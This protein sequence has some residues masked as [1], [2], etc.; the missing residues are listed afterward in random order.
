MVSAFL[1]CSPAPCYLPAIT[2]SEGIG[3]TRLTADSECTLGGIY[4]CLGERKDIDISGQDF[5]PTH[6]TLS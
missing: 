2:L 3:I 5:I 6:R 4:E 1:E